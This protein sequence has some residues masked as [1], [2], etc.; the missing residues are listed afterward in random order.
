MCKYRKNRKQVLRNNLLVSYCSKMMPYRGFG[1][2]I[3]RALNEQPN[4]A[5]I[6]DVEGE[7]F[8]VI[9]PRVKN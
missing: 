6:N 8:R 9:I 2:G 3:K 1:S 4:I 5:F 7:L